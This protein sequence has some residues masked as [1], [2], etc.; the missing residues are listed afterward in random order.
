MRY[1][2]SERLESLRLVEDIHPSAHW[3]CSEF[4]AQRF[5]AGSTDTRNATK[6][7]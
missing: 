2:A 7:G 1:L 6:L 4:T 5:T 3:E